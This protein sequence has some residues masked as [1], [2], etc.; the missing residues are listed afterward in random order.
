MMPKEDR[1]N[2]QSYGTAPYS[3][4][5]KWNSSTQVVKLSLETQPHALRT[6]TQHL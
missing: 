6:K 1:G 3:L 2:Y 5:L 4:Y